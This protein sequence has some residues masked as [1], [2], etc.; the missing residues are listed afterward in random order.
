M[1]KSAAGY[2]MKKNV[3]RAAAPTERLTRVVPT[4]RKQSDYLLSVSVAF[5]PY[6]LLYRSTRPAESTSFCR[7][8]KKGWQ[9]EQISIFRFPAVDRVS[10]VFP[11]MQ[12]TIAFLYSG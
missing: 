4:H 12:E 3:P 5:F 9:F 1:A 11:Q 8:V 7:P 6:F 10:K 2:E